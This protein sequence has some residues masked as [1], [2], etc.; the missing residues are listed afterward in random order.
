MIEVKY[1]RFFLTSKL[2]IAIHLLVEI[3]RRG[4]CL[5]KIPNHSHNQSHNHNQRNKRMIRDSIR[6]MIR[7]S[8]KFNSRFCKNRNKNMVEFK[9]QIFKNG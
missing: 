9:A 8:Q 3:L 2:W 1:L 6:I 5:E 4:E 7:K